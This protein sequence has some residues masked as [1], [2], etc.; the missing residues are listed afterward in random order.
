MLGSM[1]LRTTLQDVP[2]VRPW[3]Y[4][5]AQIAEHFRAEIR[6][7]TLK[8]GEQLPAISAIAD[9]WKVAIATVQRAMAK[10]REEGWVVARHGLGTYVAD[11]PPP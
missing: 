10:L 7:Q 11:N 6:S 9:E 3:T 1:P 8:P 2:E 5:Y 4:P